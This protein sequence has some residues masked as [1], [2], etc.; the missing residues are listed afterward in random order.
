MGIFDFLKK[1]EKAE[2]NTEIMEDIPPPNPQT[3]STMP[4]ELPEFPTTIE[5]SVTPLPR[6]QALKDFSGEDIEIP[7]LEQEYIKELV[8]HPEKAMASPFEESN[9]EVKDRKKE[10]ENE[11]P[12][13]L[14]EEIKK[15]SHVQKKVRTL[16]KKPLQV[17]G[18][19]FI[20]VND[21][22]EVL[23]DINL[24]EG[25]IKESESVIIKLNKIKINENNELKELNDSLC[26]LHKKIIFIDDILSKG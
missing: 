8:V 25:V 6:L 11:L 12:K 17:K 15:E 19:V 21:Y 13:I 10:E 2:E 4:T 7:P 1:G 9:I 26:G 22:K 24:I 23:N 18:S 14:K 5:E 20:N 3:I 16:E